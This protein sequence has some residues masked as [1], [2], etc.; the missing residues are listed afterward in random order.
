MALN[1]TLN[2]LPAL[3]VFAPAQA[4]VERHDDG[5]LV[6]IADGPTIS[7]RLVVA[8]EGR[9]SPLRDQAGIRVTHLPYG[10]TGIVCAIA[11]DLPHHGCA[12]E[13][14]LP[15][16][17]FAQLPMAGTQG[18]PNLSAIVWTERTPTAERLLRLDDAAFTRELARRMGDHLG[19]IRLLGRRW[20]Y[21]LSAMVVHRYIDTRLALAG[22]AAH[23]IHPI[24]GQG[25]NLGFRD[26]GA[27]ADLI[28][29]AAQA[30]A[31]V[32]APALL[33][34]YQ[35]QRRP[36]NMLMLAATDALDRLF[37]S[38]NPA[39]RLARGLGIGAVHR[40]PKLKR[41]FMRRAMGIPLA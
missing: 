37:S 8:A 34:R 39:L 12:L 30:G 33:A 17:P 5:A 36:D 9:R 21:P 35:A 15:A 18:A 22:D 28:I 40:L 25:L 26:I 16:G 3:R 14:F 23:G 38:D 29:G 31:D 6:H 10:Q 11:H 4:Q 2:E 41:V 1:T 20:S 24:A 27:L 19:A 7:C 13:H 32:G